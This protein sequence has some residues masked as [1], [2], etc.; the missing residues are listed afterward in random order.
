MVDPYKKAP[1]SEIEIVPA[2]LPHSFKDLGEHVQ[3]F[4]GAAI[5]CV[6]IDIVDGHFA[7]SRTWPY[8]DEGTFQKIVQEEHG[9]PLW[10]EFDFEFDLMVQD[11]VERMMDFVRAGASRVVVHAK[12]EDA[13]H[14]IQKLVDLRE[15]TGA[16]SVK[17]G[18]AI[19]CDAQPD[20]LLPFEAQFDYVQVMGIAKV[21]YQ[22][23]PFDKRAL[24]LVERLRARYP[25]L[26]LQVDGGV[27]L[28]NAHQLAK[29]G[30]TRLVVGSAIFKADDPLAAIVAL[31][32]EANRVI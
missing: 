24:Y 2:V 6:Q 25:D 23:E 31:K 29:A 11:P 15:E 8:R 17:A 1:P 9:L 13:V 14:A 19:E 26:P 12:S 10:D 22:G 21:G 30:A 28:E 4:K 27:T 16:F 32:T 5:T 7:H 3:H 18:V 20:A